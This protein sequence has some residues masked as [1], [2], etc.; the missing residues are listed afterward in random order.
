[1][2]EVPSFHPTITTFRSPALWAEAY[3]TLTVLADTWGS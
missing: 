2:L 1:M 3:F